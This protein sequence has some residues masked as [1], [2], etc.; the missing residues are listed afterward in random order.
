[1]LFKCIFNFSI[2]GSANIRFS[3]IRILEETET[4]L[5]EFTQSLSRNGHHCF[6][7][8]FDWQMTAEYDLSFKITATMLNSNTI[9][10]DTN[11]YYSIIV[12]ELQNAPP[13]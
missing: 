13:P 12:D 7:I 11:D 3:L 8:N 9:S 1:M 5:Q 4:T 2:S 6:P 10:V